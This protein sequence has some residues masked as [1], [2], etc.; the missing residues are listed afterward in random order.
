MAMIED[1]LKLTPAG[2]V[3]FLHTDEFAQMDK[4]NRVEFL[5]EIAS[6][7]G[8]SSKCLASALKILR[9]LKFRDRTFYKRFLQHPD[10]S[11]IMACKKA[12]NNR[13]FDN[14]F[15]FF[16]MRELVKKQNNEKKLET[17]KLIVSETGQAGEDM[18]LS[19]LAEDNLRV[20]EVV[21]KELS[22]RAQLDENKLLN[23]M[24]HSIWYTRAAIV[25]ILG[26]RRSQLL[27][28]K[29]GE[30]LAD[31]NVE[32]RLQLLAALSKL[33]RERA[34]EYVLKLTRDPHMRVCREAKKILATI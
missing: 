18:L 15:G 4:E 25:E 13:G 30:L 9:E 3:K 10:S 2:Q 32:V 29:I 33:D 7:E 12:L 19:F 27:F 24:S 8:I 16:P 34:K 28:D 1:F 21:V 17:V 20:R 26:N 14:G 22:G 11:V 31:P 23:Q 6:G 5:K